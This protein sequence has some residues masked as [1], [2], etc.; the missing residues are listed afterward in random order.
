VPFETRDLDSG[1]WTRT[2][3]ATLPSSPRHGT[4]LPITQSEYER[5]LA[6]YPPTEVAGP[7]A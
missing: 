3:D 5:L 1:I 7:T 4:V 2:Q 6:H